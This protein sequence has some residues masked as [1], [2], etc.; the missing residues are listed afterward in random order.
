MAREPARAGRPPPP[1]RGGQCRDQVYPALGTSSPRGCA[2]RRPR[3]ARRLEGATRVREPR[4]STSTATHPRPRPPGWSPFGMSDVPVLV[5]GV[6]RSGTTWVAQILARGG[7]ATYL[8]EPTTT[9][10]LRTRSARSADWERVPEPRSGRRRSEPRRLRGALGSPSPAA[11]RRAVAGR[12]LANRLVGRTG[13]K[14]VSAALAGSLARYPDLAVAARIAQP[15]RPQEATRSSS[16]PSTHP[17]GG[18]DRVESRRPCGLRP[19]KPAQRAV[20]LISSTGCRP[21]APTCSRRS[22]RRSRR[23]SRSATRRRRRHGRRSPAP[24]G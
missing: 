16:S 7:Q 24:R 17:R 8:E 6:P 5:V 3:A 13:P 15:E 23:S 4:T 20:E 14:R 22:I 11:R 19:A 12:A 18:V 10:A 2:V 1:R 9:S 21:P